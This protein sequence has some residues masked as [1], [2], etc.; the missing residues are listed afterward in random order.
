M[1]NLE[2]R[3][4]R[5]P[6]TDTTPAT[7]FP[8]TGFTTLKTANTIARLVITQYQLLIVPWTADTPTAILSQVA[9]PGGTM[10]RSSR[11]DDELARLVGRRIRSV[12]EREG[13]TQE[14]LAEALGAGT[15]TIS[16]YETAA[17]P[18]SIARLQQ[19]AD[20]LNT[21]MAA[22]LQI[23]SIAVA[24]DAK[25]VVVLWLSLDRERRQVLLQFLRKFTGK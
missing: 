11:C 24:D 6:N 15:D 7:P 25:E 18:V 14:H 23:E 16:R 13:L 3:T 22:L 2:Q 10:S 19:I 8:G 4:A 12:R 9:E 20:A 17:I 1:M 21:D 5:V